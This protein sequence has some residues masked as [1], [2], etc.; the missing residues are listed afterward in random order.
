M[1]PQE[2]YERTKLNLTGEEYAEVEALYNIVPD[3]D[4]DEFC[5]L[6]MKL[7]DNL[8]IQALGKGVLNAIRKS[9]EFQQ[10]IARKKVQIDQLSEAHKKEM[11]KIGEQYNVHMK[12][13]GRKMIVNMNDSIH[14]YDNITEEFGYDFLLRVK[15]EE[16]IDLDS[17]E[18]EYLA[19]KLQ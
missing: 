4:K 10:E 5:K 13:F 8:L 12:D 15:L 11:Q 16:N 18:R 17:K 1:L 7:K 14:L 2:F 3:I 19:K 6:W 9:D